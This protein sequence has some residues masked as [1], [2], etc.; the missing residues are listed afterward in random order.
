[1]SAPESLTYKGDAALAGASS[2]PAWRRQ[3]FDPR[4]IWLAP[5][6]ALIGYLTIPPILTVLYASLQSDFLSDES[7]WTLAHYVEHFTTARHLEVILNSL[8]Y[9]AGTMTFATCNGALL[10][11]LFTHTDVPLRRYLFVLGMLP[12]LIPGLLNTFA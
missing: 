12:F 10:A 3:S 9:A 11:F 8:L 5:I 1:M 7:T 4:L 6:I 2:R